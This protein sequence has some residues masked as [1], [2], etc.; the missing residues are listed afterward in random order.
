MHALLDGVA[1]DEPVHHRRPLLADAVHATD[2]L[3]Q[4]SGFQDIKF[5]YNISLIDSRVVKG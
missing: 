5:N 3:K 2:G 4:I 1:D